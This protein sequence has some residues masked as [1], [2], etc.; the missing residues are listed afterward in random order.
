M[1]N[2]F[3]RIR[4]S[5]S[6]P[7]AYSSFQKDLDSKAMEQIFFNTLSGKTS[8]RA[9][10][11]PENSTN[12]SNRPESKAIRVRPLDIHDFIL[13]EPCSFQDHSKIKRVLAMHPVAYPDSSYPFLGGDLEG[14]D[15]VGYGHIVE[16]FFKDGPQ[17]NGNLRGLTYRPTTI[18]LA[19]DFNIEC[20]GV[21]IET[22]GASVGGYAS[23]RGDK[24][25][26]AQIAFTRDKYQP[27]VPPPAGVQLGPFDMDEKV[28]SY[29]VSSTVE[30]IA[31]Y[32]TVDNKTNS[33]SKRIYNGMVEEFKGKVVS[34]GLL[35][36]EILGQLP[37]G[38]VH[39]GGSFERGV[40]II[41]TIRD[42]QRLA[43]AFENKFKMKL[44]LS[45]SY[46]TF[47]RQ[48]KTKNKKINAG[49]E[50][51]AGITP[52]MSEKRKKEIQNK[53]RLKKIEAATPGRSPHGWG[54][55]FDMNTEYDGKFGYAS[56][57]FN[58]VMINGPKYNFHSPPH[59]RDGKG[60]EEWWHF[61]WMHTWKIYKKV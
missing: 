4:R 60:L 21:E 50:I 16:C 29:V 53:A 19:R 22:G 20:L 13:P 3:D 15:P 59:M 34:N 11:L 56:D 6:S 33:P 48:I 36:K 30:N 52:E 14:V 44:N 47:N 32:K 12:S 57:T 23:S 54:L 2:I 55:A 5:L 37:P 38:T 46:R 7:E 35:P 10:V 28:N 61:E 1:S 17:S 42:F 41:D 51:L 45:D 8:F 58:W 31:T 26:K 39:P 18:G 27:Y 24:A 40:V 9:V 43:M 25:S 49:N